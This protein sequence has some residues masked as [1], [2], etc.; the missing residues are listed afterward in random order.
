MTWS[1]RL[2]RRLDIAPPAAV[3]DARLGCFCDALTELS[4]RTMLHD[5][6]A[7]ALR[8]G[9]RGA[10]ALLDV[11]RFG[12]FNER[13]GR[14][15]GDELLRAVAARLRDELAPAS[16]LARAGGDR[17][18]AFLPGLGLD[19]ATRLAQRCV[20][21]MHEPVVLSCGPQVVSLSAGVAALDGEPGVAAE[22]VWAACEAALRAARARAGS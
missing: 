8:A 18:A 17:F 11:D 9:V 15:R 12:H 2:K 19:A 16:C 13:H 3:V 14:A 22:A 4:T 1:G 7:A 6:V 21:A 10:V 20:E 5:T